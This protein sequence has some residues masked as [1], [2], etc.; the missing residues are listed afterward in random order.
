MSPDRYTGFGPCPHCFESSGFAA[1]INHATWEEPSWAEPDPNCPC[2]YCDH[3]GYVECE[4]R[5]LDDLENE[6]W[7]AGTT[8]WF[9]DLHELSRGEAA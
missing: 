3:T 8:K 2:P 9:G 7:S 5:T 4:P 6:E 1:R